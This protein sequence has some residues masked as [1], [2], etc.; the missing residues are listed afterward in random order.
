[1][2]AL[3]DIIQHIDVT[4]QHAMEWTEP[5]E[6]MSK[7]TMQI[8]RGVGHRN[9]LADLLWCS[10][11]L[12]QSLEGVVMVIINR[13]SCLD[14]LRCNTWRI[15]LNYWFLSRLTPHQTL[16]PSEKKSFWAL[17]CKS[18]TNYALQNI[19]YLLVKKI[20]QIEI[21]EFIQLSYKSWIAKKN[22]VKLTNTLLK[23]NFHNMKA[24]CL[25]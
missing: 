13:S 21:L 9:K 6:M 8:R 24:Q 15:H 25:L 11:Y 20:Q 19:P 1:M 23:E 10:L 5:E 2:I 18:N 17:T 22:Y 16:C 7:N 14:N 3:L 12:Q 4:T